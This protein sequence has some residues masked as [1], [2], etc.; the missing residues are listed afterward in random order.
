MTDSILDT[1]FT[2][3]EEKVAKFSAPDMFIASVA[4]KHQQLKESEAIALLYINGDQHRICTINGDECIIRG[5]HAT[6]GYVGAAIQWVSKRAPR[7]LVG[8][9]KRS[10]QIVKYSA[11]TL[12][13]EYLEDRV[14]A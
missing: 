1:N 12:T 4:I 7:H 14:T 6:D 5:I 3:L 9:G 8:S 10:Y 13:D 11:L 2:N